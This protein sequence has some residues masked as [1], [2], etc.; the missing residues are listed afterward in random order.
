MQ[1]RPS[2]AGVEKRYHPKYQLQA[3]VSVQLTLL[4]VVR[5]R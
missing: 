4:T 5:L 3:V 2:E 1:L